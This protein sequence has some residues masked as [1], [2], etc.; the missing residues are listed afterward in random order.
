M[1]DNRPQKS[2]GEQ[3][4]STNRVKELEADNKAVH[5]A[6]NKLTEEGHG[7]QDLLKVLLG[8]ALSS[9]SLHHTRQTL[10]V[11]HPGGGLKSCKVS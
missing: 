2:F 11:R 10:S 9:V 1:C 3:I 6:L 8:Y 7:D 5:A 4:M